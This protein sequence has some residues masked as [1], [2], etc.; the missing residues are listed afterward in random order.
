ML[1]SSQEADITGFRSSASHYM[2]QYGAI[3]GS[4]S[5]TG[6]QQVGGISF[7]FA[8]VQYIPVYLCN[9]IFISRRCI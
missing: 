5:M 4:A 6:A 7:S 3:Y 8:F 2:G 1:S 9:F